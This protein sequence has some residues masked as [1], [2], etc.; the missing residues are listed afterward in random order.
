MA[1]APTRKETEAKATP[2]PSDDR[3]P[4]ERMTDLTRRVVNVPKE[5]A[6]AS[7]QRPRRAPH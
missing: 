4:L 3:T 5:E 7:K 2:P 6:V 1:K